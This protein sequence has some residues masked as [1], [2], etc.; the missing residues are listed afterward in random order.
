M[1]ITLRFPGL[2][3]AERVY[4]AVRESMAELHPWAPWCPLSYSLADATSWIAQ[5]PAARE[6]GTAFEFL[7]VGHDGGL[8]GCCGVNQINKGFRL[9]NLGYW[10]RSSATR[11]GFATEASRQVAAWSFQNTNLQRLEFLVAVGN[12]PSQAVALK[13]GALLEG[14]LRSRFLVHGQF[15][16]AF[17]YS[18][19]RP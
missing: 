1:N 19:I 15:Q 5:Q 13:T 17:V 18:L 12:A 2:E 7:V 9:A 11:R 4:D 14:C 3:D 6:T 8:L 16:D 10:I